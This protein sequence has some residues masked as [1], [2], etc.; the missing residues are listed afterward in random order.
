MK[1]KETEEIVT[2]L[3]KKL[4]ELEIQQRIVKQSILAV[5]KQLSE[6]KAESKAIDVRHI[7]RRC[8]ILNPRL[9]QPSEG[10]IVGLTKGKRPFIKVKEKGFQEIRRL[11]KNLQLLEHN[12]DE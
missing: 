6:L 10:I 2:E 8:R 11:A 5:E 9:H 7:G 3:S 1:N 12:E 4:S